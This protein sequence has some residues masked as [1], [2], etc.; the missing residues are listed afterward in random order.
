[1]NAEKISNFQL[2]F[3]NPIWQPAA[4]LKIEISIDSLDF[5]FCFVIRNISAKG[6]ICTIIRALRKMTSLICKTY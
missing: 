3:G 6:N 2:N 1:M 4:I 5:A